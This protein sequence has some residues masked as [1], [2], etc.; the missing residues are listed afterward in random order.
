M[1]RAGWAA[2]ALGWAAAPGTVVA[3][4]LT[5][6]LAA[7][8]APAGAWLGKSLV[9][10]L[11]RGR[12]GDL[13]RVTLLAIAGAGV[14]AC[15]LALTHASAYLVTRHEAAVA[16]RTESDLFARVCSFVGLRHFEDPDFHDRL[17]VAEN[18]AAE[19][20]NG[21][22]STVVNVAQAVVTL[23]GFLA[24]LALVWPAVAGLLL[25]AA[26]PGL[27]AEI[28]L[29]RRHAEA[30][31]S[32]SPLQ[33]RRFFYRSLL[34]DQRAAKE[35]RLYGLGDFFRV[36][37]LAALRG[38][39]EV[40]VSLAART[41]IVQSGLTLLGAVVSG[42]AIV[43]VARR[44]MTGAL[45]PGDVLLFMLAVVGVQ[46][47]LSQIVAEIGTSGRSLKLFQRY[48]D[49]VR[50]PA[51]L[52]G[53]DLPAPPLRQRLRFD[54]VWFRYRGDS[55]WVLRG[56]SFDLPAGTSLGLVGVNGA[57]KSTLVKLLCRFYDPE[58]GRILWDGTD[59]R[60]FDPGSLRRR[61]AATFQDF[62]SYDLT[63][64]ENIGVG[65]LARRDD[66]TAVQRCAEQAGIHDA[67]DGLPQGYHT[68]LSRIFFTELD[69]DPGVTLSGGQWQRVALARSLMRADADLLILDEPSSGLDAAAEHQI[70]RTLRRFRG[71]RTS[72][73]ISHRL[74]S[75][76]DADRIVVLHDGVVA[77]QG[78]H[79]SLMRS[80]GTYARLFTVQA[81]GYQAA[82][83]GL[84]AAGDLE[85]AG[86]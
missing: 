28:R 21:I 22:M 65:D 53:G 6:L 49:V 60:E 54:N 35:V 15:G 79:E 77:E 80:G 52:V 14:A 33:R 24:A 12:S 58:R 75:L 38:S 17:S 59:L 74:G 73:L 32:A 42:G 82:G 57:G 26:L 2:L 43:L 51:E 16:L 9:D 69:S 70:H 81:R 67:I 61:M 27:V 5:S 47:A 41:A 50:A 86:R 13:S 63:A 48:L 31:M 83:E 11:T 71:S 40:M 29:A 84:E 68:L 7:A 3:R 39:Q 56:V 64:G 23:A 85:V 37:Q 45:T 30:T 10:E 25:V 46:S 8:A 4:L 20:P 36:R 18:S 34:T 76:R 72:L 44:A 19:G 66:L 55:P 62:M 1:I 78:D